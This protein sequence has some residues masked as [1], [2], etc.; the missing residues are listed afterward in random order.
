MKSTKPQ[1]HFYSKFMRNME[2]NKQNENNKTALV[3]EGGGSRGMFT[4]GILESFLANNINFDSVFGVSAGA[5]YGASFVSKQKGR[6]AKLND[7]I[8]D[9]R[10]GGLWH[11]LKSGSYFS[12]DFIFGE[13]AHEIAPYDYEAFYNSSDFYVGASDCKTGE[14]EF[15][16]TNTLEKKEF[17]AVLKASGSLPFI[18][19]IV[20]Y[21]GKEYLD[22]GLTNSIPYDLAFKQGTEKVVVV[23]TRPRGYEKS[24]MK[25]NKICKWYFR[26]HPKIYE[27]LI[28]RASLYNES[29][30]KLRE[31]ENEGKVYVIYPPEDLK[32]SR[33]ERDSKKTEKVYCDAIKYGEEILP[34]IKEWLN[35]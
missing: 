3:L 16:H 2:N 29:I 17:M 18:S 13:L 33:V 19:P 32:V 28:N 6:N 24:K 34:N 10:Y 1:L 25:P 26:K 31:L 8:G 35:K 20:Q 22:G 4:A 27:A 30:K 5:M 7:Y 12:W 11:L 21:K 14:S 15:F 9:K 23:L